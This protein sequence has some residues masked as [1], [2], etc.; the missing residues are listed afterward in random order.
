VYRLITACC[1]Q[2]N[3]IVRVFI[4][5]QMDFVRDSESL[6]LSEASVTCKVTWLY[7]G[8]RC[9]RMGGCSSAL[10]TEHWALPRDPDMRRTSNV[11]P[12]KQSKPVSHPFSVPHGLRFIIFAPLV[13]PL[14]SFTCSCCSRERALWFTLFA[15]RHHVG[16]SQKSKEST[17]S[18][19]YTPL[20]R[21]LIDS[22][23]SQRRTKGARQG[24]RRGIY[25]C[26]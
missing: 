11:F 21:W 1:E 15:P 3:I 4:G 26:D 19:I 24:G 20:D 22:T 9:V 17:R 18:N 5:N 12:R 25:T 23:P 6:S 8:A 7:S 13:P 14:F 2:G 10:G 16:T